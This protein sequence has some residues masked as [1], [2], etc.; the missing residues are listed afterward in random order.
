MVMWEYPK[1]ATVDD[2]MG[3]SYSKAYVVRSYD[4]G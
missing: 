3:Y 4:R 1:A 2:D